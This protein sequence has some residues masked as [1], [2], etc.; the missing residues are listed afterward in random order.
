MYVAIFSNKPDKDALGHEVSLTEMGV[1]RYLL[2]DP[3]PKRH[4]LAEVYRHYL[5][6]GDFA[7]AT[8][9]DL[10]AYG[11]PN[12]KATRVVFLAKVRSLLEMAELAYNA[13]RGGVYS[14]YGQRVMEFETAKNS[15]WRIAIFASLPGDVNKYFSSLSPSDV[16]VVRYKKDSGH[17]PSRRGRKRGS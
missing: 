8:Q 11:T 15:R 10:L 16:R 6:S 9:S 5:P 12:V 14:V 17:R 7:I 4:R 2:L 1:G 13:V 3:S